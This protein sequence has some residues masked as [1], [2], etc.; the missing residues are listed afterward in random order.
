M[1]PFKSLALEKQQKKLDTD[2][3]FQNLLSLSNEHDQAF[4]HNDPAFKLN[5]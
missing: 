4:F 1:T 5:K 3:M 2:R